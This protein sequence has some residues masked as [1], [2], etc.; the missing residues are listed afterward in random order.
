MS[1]FFLVYLKHCFGAHHYYTSHFPLKYIQNESQHIQWIVLLLFDYMLRYQALVGSSRDY[2]FILSCRTPCTSSKHF[3]TSKQPQFVSFIPCF[4]LLLSF[5][6]NLCLILE[7]YVSGDMEQRGADAAGAVAVG[8]S[9]TIPGSFTV[10]NHNGL[11]SYALVVQHD[12]T[13]TWKKSER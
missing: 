7:R 1:Y 5:F 8:G 13:G 4:F 12:A 10:N 3:W 2:L 6:H 11:T 9:L